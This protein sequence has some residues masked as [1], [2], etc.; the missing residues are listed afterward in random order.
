MGP[1]GGARGAGAAR[2]GNLVVMG[3]RGSGKS[4]LC[5]RAAAVDKRLGLLPLD[6][7][8]QFEA[9]GR[10]VEEIVAER[11]WPGF[12]DL[13]FEVAEKAGSMPGWALV[14]CGGGA[15][16]GPPVLLILPPPVRP[17][18]PR[19]DRPTRE[20]TGPR[21][22]SGPT[23]PDPLRCRLQGSSLTWTRTGRRFTVT[24]RFRPSS[25]TGWWCMCGAR[26]PTSR[27]G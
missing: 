2:K 7:L 26:W 23:P 10:S 3:G 14:D 19:L 25:G 22:T 27:S 18:L 13:E 24:A 6:E 8:I 21:A 15:H 12:R 1:P 5:R 11:G 4:S 20:L 16:P 9:Y 17:R